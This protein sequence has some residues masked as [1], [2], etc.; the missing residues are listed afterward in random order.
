MPSKAPLS[1][2]LLFARARVCVRATL[3]LFLISLF[4]H[5]CC[6]NVYEILRHR[7][8]MG[9]CLVALLTMSLL[10]RKLSLQI[11]RHWMV[12]PPP[13]LIVETLFKYDK[14]C[15]L[16]CYGKSSHV[17][18]RRSN[19][20]HI[21]FHYRTK[22]LTIS[23]CGARARGETIQRKRMSSTASKNMAARVVNEWASGKEGKEKKIY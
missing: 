16:L 12:S 14:S 2:F 10:F 17:F 8:C 19:T 3:L 20:L 22:A 23:R 11:H 4:F 9:Y 6:C 7:P 5:F 15:H 13:T 21:V 1:L 18:C